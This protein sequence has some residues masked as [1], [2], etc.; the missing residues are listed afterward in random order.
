MKTDIG[1]MDPAIITAQGPLMPP[2]IRPTLPHSQPVMSQPMFMP[3][4]SPQMTMRAPPPQQY[5]TQRPP[6]NCEELEKELI[7]A[8]DQRGYMVNQN[9]VNY[10][11]TAQ[12]A[13][14]SLQQNMQQI[15]FAS[16]NKAGNMPKIQF[17]VDAPEFIPRT[18]TPGS[19]NAGQLAVSHEQLITQAHLQQ[20]QTSLPVSMPMSMGRASPHIG[21]ISTIAGTIIPQE[22][23]VSS[24]QQLANL[25]RSSP[26]PGAAPFI[27]PKVPLNVGNPHGAMPHPGHP[28][29]IYT[30]VPQPYPPQFRPTGYAAYHQQ[31]QG[32][33][34]VQAWPGGRK[35]H[36]TTF[37][38]SHPVSQQKTIGMGLKG[39][40][41][42]STKSNQHT[43]QK[44]PH[45]SQHEMSPQQAKEKV[46]T[47]MKQGK[48][49]LIILRG[50]PGSG[51]STIAR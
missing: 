8:S 32:P 29:L 28:G 18:Y 37:H 49:V 6:L 1:Q 24:S 30:P 40:A 25:G 15:N 27:L 46:E 36:T 42:G 50:L 23:I 44:I 45:R 14:H 26:I 39:R 2:Q 38:H 33:F 22:L 47:L 20:M 10:N 35:T 11:T 9:T 7:N 16:L 13:N 43:T 3:R 21:P 48:K 34:L 41:G 31:Y 19:N 12:L 51:K 4:T 17:S 5:Y